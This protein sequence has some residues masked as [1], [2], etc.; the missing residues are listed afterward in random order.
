MY[1]WAVIMECKC[2]CHDGD[3]LAAHDSL[4]CAVPNGLRR[5]NPYKKL[6]S[7]EFY[8]KILKESF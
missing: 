7:P 8:K 4:C 6:E 1:K 2:S 5:K 3:G